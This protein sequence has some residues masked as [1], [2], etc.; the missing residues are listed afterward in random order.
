MIS[1]SRT[2]VGSNN[3]PAAGQ[4]CAV[5]SS[6]SL[7]R[8][9]CKARLERIR[10]P[11]S[12]SIAASSA[13]TG[14][15][16]SAAAVGVGARRSAAKSINV[17]SVSCPTALIN[18]IGDS[19]AAR[20]TISSLNAHRSSIDPPPRATMIRSGGLTIA[21]KPRI[22]AATCPA[23]A[24]PWTGTG[25]SRTCVGQRSARRCKISRITAP[26]GE[27]TIPIVLG[28]NGRRRFFASSN[29]PSAAS[30]RRRLSSSAI[31]APSPASSSRS[32]T[33]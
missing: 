13:S 25:H 1:P 19:A 12:R 3:R 23:A 31:S 33:N 7:A 5:A 16:I 28:R 26:V 29:N 22:A 6:R 8:A 9:A 27:V 30:A 11:R 21:P 10:D 18:G 14:T 32:T 4:R 17:V 15:A 24:S 2:A 20:T